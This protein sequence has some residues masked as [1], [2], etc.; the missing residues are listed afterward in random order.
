MPLDTDPIIPLN[1]LVPNPDVRFQRFGLN[2]SR[3]FGQ[4]LLASGP[5][6]PPAA[7][8][9]AAAPAKPPEAALNPVRVEALAA[10]YSARSET[11][12]E[13]AAGSR[14]DLRA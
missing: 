7:P 11:R 8:N 14:V 10:G 12:T 2:D 4:P 6:I 13:P 5:R 9:G 3:L 1:R